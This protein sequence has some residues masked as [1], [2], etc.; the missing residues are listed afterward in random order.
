MKRKRQPRPCHPSGSS[1]DDL[2]IHVV[3]EEV[4]DSLEVVRPRGLQEAFRNWEV[5]EMAMLG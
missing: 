5:V 4:V 3:E 2:S 1:F